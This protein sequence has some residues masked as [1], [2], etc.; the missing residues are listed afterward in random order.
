M[1]IVEKQIK[2]KATYYDLMTHSIVEK[3][4]ENTVTFDSASECE[5]FLML[6]RLF[7]VREFGISI[8][9]PI[10]CN[11]ICWRVDFKVQPVHKT[12]A[13]YHRLGGLVQ[14]INGYRYAVP[15]TCIYFEFKGT[16]DR[17]FLEKFSHIKKYNP[18]IANHIILASY[19]DS[20]FGKYDESDRI[21][22]THPIIGMNNLEKI[23][24]ELIWHEQ[25]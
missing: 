18:S 11:G 20:A 21:F 4:S 7:P 15:P 5:F 19:Y 16:Q 22:H 23:T 2:R 24:K 6:E 10:D 14:R 25:S 13:Q 8:H 1:P 17:N 9:V 12:L 3:K